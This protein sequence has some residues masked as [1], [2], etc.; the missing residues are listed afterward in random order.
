[1]AILAL[2]TVSVADNPNADRL[3]VYQFEGAPDGNLVQIVANNT[4]IYQPGDVVAC[5]LVGTVLEDGTEIKKGKFRGVR[6]FGMAMGKT[7]KPVGTDLTAEFNA[8]HV[9]KKIDEKTGVISE[10][11]WV[12]YTSIDGY[13]KLREDILA[14]DEIIVTEKSHGCFS[15][16]TRIML[17]NGEERTFQ[18]VVANEGITHVLSRDMDSGEFISRPITAKVVRPNGGVKWVRVNLENDRFIICTEEHPFWSNDRCTWVAA[19]DLR[20]NEDV[21]SPND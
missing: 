1:M 12:K 19:K 14:C 11:A 17:P 5:A 9:E 3:K 20:P 15:A 18:E 6:S 7:D 21:S 13:L 2:R 8:T 10:D 16:S 4:N